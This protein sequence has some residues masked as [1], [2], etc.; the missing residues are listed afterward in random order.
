M[1]V[2][3]PRIATTRPATLCL[4]GVL[5]LFLSVPRLAAQ[6]PAT[7]SGHSS[8][9]AATAK[10]ST[11]AKKAVSTKKRSA[12]KS[13]AA[14]RSHTRARSRA[15]HHRTRRRYLSRAARIAHTRRIR[16]AFVAS[17]ELRPMARQ[18][19]T[20]RTA[21]AY[22]GVT[23]YAHSHSGEAAAAA[24]LALGHAYLLDH[25][26]SEA[27]TSFRAALTHDGELGDYSDY[28]DAE[29]SHAAGDDAAAEKLL[30]G[31]GTRYPDSVFTDQAPVLEA[32]VLLA[33]NDSTGAQKALA[34]AIGTDEDATPAFRLA[35]AQVAR[36][37]GG[38]G[39]AI[40]L[41]VI[42]I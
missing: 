21:A 32:N 14:T 20:M 12:R 34:E 19:A 9:S 13:S 1:M 2:V 16:L 29:A 27:E 11:T 24:Y 6:S 10:K 39:K 37:R 15:R 40:D 5:S 31:F 17:T 36:A 18:L 30:R 28:L 42:H 22:A 23:A 3:V 41:C 33:L 25:R 8:H 38:R 26:Y 35:D 7:S 4:T